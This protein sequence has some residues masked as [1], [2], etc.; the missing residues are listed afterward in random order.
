[1]YDNQFSCAV[2]ENIYLLTYLLTYFSMIVTSSIINVFYST[3]SLDLPFVTLSRLPFLFPFPSFL[4]AVVP[5]DTGWG[6][7]SLFVYCTLELTEILGTDDS[8]GLSC[9]LQ[10]SNFDWYVFHVPMSVYSIADQIKYYLPLHTDTCT[11]PT[12][13][14]FLSFFMYVPWRLNFVMLHIL[15]TGAVGAGGWGD[16]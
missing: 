4:N 8:I 13:Y 15:S 7:M 16:G 2:G 1:M 6:F 11:Y 9:H 10:I 5:V 3:I 12:S 14:I